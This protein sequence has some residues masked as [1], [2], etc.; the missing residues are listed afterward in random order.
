MDIQMPE[1]DGL[2]ATRHIRAKLPIEQQPRIIAMTAHAI[3]EYRRASF[4]AGMDGFTTKPVQAETIAS[5]LRETPVVAAAE[6]SL[7]TA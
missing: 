2:E 6:A 7:H 3:E 1:M 5:A 4:E